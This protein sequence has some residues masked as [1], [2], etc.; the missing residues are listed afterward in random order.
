MRLEDLVPPLG[1]CKLIP[2]GEFQDS[3]FVWRVGKPLYNGGK[4]Y[5]DIGTRSCPLVDIQQIPAPT[6]QEILVNMPDW[7]RL[8]V[9]FVNPQI[10]LKLKKGVIKTGPAEVLRLWLTMKGIKHD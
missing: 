3:Y 5:L 1:L 7:S 2:D 8:C 6:L 4:I 10:T 9:D